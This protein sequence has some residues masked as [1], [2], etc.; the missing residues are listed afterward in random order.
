MVEVHATRGAYGIR[1]PLH[2]GIVVTI[3]TTVSQQARVVAAIQWRRHMVQIDT[4]VRAR[5]SWVTTTTIQCKAITVPHR[6]KAHV[7]PTKVFPRLAV[8]KTILKPRLTAAT[9]GQY[10]YVGFSRSNKIQRCSAYTISDKAIRFRHPDYK[11]D[12]AQKLI[13]SSTSPTFCRHATFHPNLCTRF[14]VILLTDRQTD[15]RTRA[16]TFPSYFVGGNNMKL[17]HWP[18]MGGLLHLIQWG[19]DWAGP[20]PAIWHVALESWYWIRQVAAPWNAAGGSGSTCH[21]IRPNIRHIGILLLVSISAIS[22]QS[23]CHSAPVCEV[24]SKSDYPR[25]KNDV[26]SVFKMA[27][28]RH[29]GF[30]GSTNWFFEKPMYDFL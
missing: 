30:Y 12:R 5:S 22:P 14:W 25:Q 18:L 23:T 8:N 11:P 7:L 16:K 21:W 3:V 27:D 15:K 28:F 1:R 24:L 17:V 9:G 29:L 4:F 6:T 26:M 13:S 20:H 2:P 10:L 19:G